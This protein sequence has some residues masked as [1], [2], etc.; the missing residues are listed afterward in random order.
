MKTSN[1]ERS[2]IMAVRK[3]SISPAELIQRANPALVGL[4][5]LTGLGDVV[6]SPSFDDQAFTELVELNLRKNEFIRKAAHDLRNPIG[7]VKGYLDLILAGAF[8][9]LSDGLTNA[10][11]LMSASCE[12][13]LA[14]TNDLLS[15]AVIEGSDLHVEW[16]IVDVR[17]FLFECVSA[18]DDFAARKGIR[19]LVDVPEDFPPAV[20]DTT[21]MRVALE[22]LLS[23]AIK[24]SP[25]ERSVTVSARSD[26]GKLTL[27]VRDEGLGIPP[28]EMSLLF[29]PFAKISVRPTN[30]E[31]SS[32]LGLWMVKRIVEAHG[33]E[34]WAESEV[35]KGS[36]FS[37]RIPVSCEVSLPLP[38][39][40]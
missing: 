1:P 8:G 15:P 9:P 36:T 37:F 19:L 10:L 20:F 7:S 2:R 6:S 28:E 13:A 27:S 21:H 34:V 17:E 3:P 24:F 40:D 23:N 12:T 11:K 32:R 38:E 4:I 30:G 31:P 26:E 35:G 39:A 18:M 25:P 29:T 16:N 14:I 5:P 22:N 33:G